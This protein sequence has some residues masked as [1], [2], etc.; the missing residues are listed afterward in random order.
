MPP[1]PDQGGGMASPPAARVGYGSTDGFGLSNYDLNPN[2][3]LIDREFNVLAVIDWDSVVTLPD[4][5][6]YC[7]P[8]LMGVSCAVPGVVVTR[9]AM[10]KREQLGRRFAEVVEAVGREQAGSKGANILP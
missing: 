4:A 7:F 1:V 5:A 10:M 8:F 9:P 3:I 6:L 2:S